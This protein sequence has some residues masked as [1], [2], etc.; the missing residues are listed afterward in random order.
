M[1][2]TIHL[3]WQPAIAFA[4]M[5]S[6]TCVIKPV[7]SLLP[8]LLTTAFTKKPRSTRRL[9]HCSPVG[10]PAPNTAY[11]CVF[12]IEGADALSDAD[13]ARRLCLLVKEEGDNVANLRYSCREMC[14]GGAK[15]SLLFLWDVLSTTFF[16]EKAT[17]AS[18]LENHYVIRVNHYVIR[19]TT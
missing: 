16:R 6:A 5:Q 17:R 3:P 9:T 18:G 13:N 7:F 8:G 2:S 11:V 10:P 1:L 4:W 15:L 12:V 19:Y 14:R